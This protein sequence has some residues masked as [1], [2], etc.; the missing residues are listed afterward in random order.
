M[1]EPGIAK[2]RAVFLIKEDVAFGSLDVGNREEADTAVMGEV[3]APPGQS[4][5]EGG[6][7]YGE[8]R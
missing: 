2:E 8:P 7:T 6:P 1:C 5:I 4:V 3:I